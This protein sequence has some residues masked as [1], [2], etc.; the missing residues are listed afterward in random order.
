MIQIPAV[1]GFAYSKLSTY[2]ELVSTFSVSG[3]TVHD[4]GP[5]SDPSKRV[6]GISY[7]DLSKPVVFIVGSI[8]GAHEWRGAHWVTKF[9][10]LIANGWSI[11]HQRWVSQVRAA[12]SFYA[13][14]CA[15]PHGYEASTRC[16]ANG[17]DLNRNFDAYWDTYSRTGSC[18]GGKGSAPFSEPEAQIIRDAVLAYKPVL[19]VDCHT[20]GSAT[21][22]T[23]EYGSTYD[24]RWQRW[25]DDVAMSFL[26]T[27]GVTPVVRYGSSLGRTPFSQTWATQQSGRTGGL[28]TLACAIEPGSRETEP[29][30]ARLGMTMLLLLSLHALHWY[31]RRSLSIRRRS[32]ALLLGG[33]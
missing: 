13:I 4:L 30:Q 21:G 32:E 18:P 15:N 9:M 2:D 29:D 19:F 24:V 6:Y 16:N 33:A 23:I 1:P 14:P 8:H 25:I 12:F 10:D 28:Q 7:G 11:H 3:C 17:V 22:M 20:Q 27:T 5:S 31:R 26:L